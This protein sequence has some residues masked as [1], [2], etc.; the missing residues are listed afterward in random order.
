VIAESGELSHTATDVAK[1]GEVSHII[2]IAILTLVV[3]HGK[4]L[5]ERYSM[6]NHRLFYR[7][8][9]LADVIGC[10][11]SKAYELVASGAIPSVRIGTLLRVP[12]SAL[13]ELARPTETKDAT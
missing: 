7:V 6:N 9:E 10:S 11:K 1:L 12:S 5:S 2:L 4:L 13:E 8:S 3:N